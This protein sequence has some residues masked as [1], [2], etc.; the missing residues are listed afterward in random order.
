MMQNGEEKIAAEGSRRLLSISLV[1][2]GDR[3]MTIPNLEITGVK[4]LKIRKFGDRRGCFFKSWRQSDHPGLNFVQDNVSMSAEPGTVRG[5]HYQAPPY[6]QAKL[7]T[8][9]RGAI[10]DVAV[11]LRRGS[12]TYGRWTG[13]ELSTENLSQL[14]IPAGFA[15]GFCTLEPDTVVHYKV[16]AYYS[17]AHEGGVLW[18]DPALAIAWPTEPV[19]AV[20]SAKDQGLPPLAMVKSPFTYSA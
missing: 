16:D 4:L 10:F 8:V 3:S 1:A 14:L 6:A 9:L 7:V 12:P 13:A 19:R 5:L 15:H 11:D 20:V 17:P 2:P 18:H